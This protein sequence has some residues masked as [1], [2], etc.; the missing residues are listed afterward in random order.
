MERL[1]SIESEE[2]FHDL[3]KDVR[4]ALELSKSF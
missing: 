3:V 2:N 4:A 1:E